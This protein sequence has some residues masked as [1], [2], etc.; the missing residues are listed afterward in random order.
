MGPT[1]LSYRNLGMKHAVKSRLRAAYAHV[2]ARRI[3]GRGVPGA[4]D[5]VNLA[6]PEPVAAGMA[7]PLSPAPV[8]FFGVT[9]HLIAHQ[10]F[11]MHQ[12]V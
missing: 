6:V 1:R 9:R 3:A 5:I 4:A 7:A 2:K 10:P 12:A 8:E 11:M